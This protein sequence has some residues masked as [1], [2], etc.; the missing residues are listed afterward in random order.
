[1]KV[2]IIVIILLF[3]IFL[4]ILSQ[5]LFDAWNEI[6]KLRNKI[7][8]LIKEKAQWNTSTKNMSEEN[9]LCSEATITS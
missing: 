2:I 5:L 9:S 4:I 7:D 1:M 6:D 8:E 3:V